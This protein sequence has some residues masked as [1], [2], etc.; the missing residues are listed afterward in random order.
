VHILPRP[1]VVVRSTALTAPRVALAFA[2]ALLGAASSARAADAGEAAPAPDPAVEA[3]QQY[4]AGTQA[5][6]AKRFVE[7]ALHFEAAA[8]QRAHAVTLY[9]AA[10]A[11]EQSNRPERAADDFERALDVPGLNPAQTTNARERLAALEKTMGTLDVVAAPGVRVQIDAL[12]EVAAPAKLHALPGAHALTVRAPD[13]PIAHRDVS[14][15]LGQTSRLDLTEAEPREAPATAAP[16][17]RI[18]APV[19]GVPAAPEVVRVVDVRRLG[20]AVALG[21]GGATLV[22]AVVLGLGALDAR[23]AYDASPTRASYDH[24]SSLQTWTNVALVGGSVLAAGGAL[25]IAWPSPHA[26]PVAGVAGLRLVPSPGG[27][28][29]RGAF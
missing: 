15:E 10:L 29:V 9:T 13:R 2:L 25:L 26:P 11:W 7:A 18:E 16:E 22:A 5:Y 20:G 4:N 1:G 23:D 28:A 24:A 3:R 21:A 6:A 19:P 12:T 17:P 14:V 8:A 27:A